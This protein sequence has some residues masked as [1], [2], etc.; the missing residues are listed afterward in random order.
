MSF[1][2]K[3]LNSNK[4]AITEFMSASSSK[5]VLVRSFCD[6][7]KFYLIRTNFR[8]ALNFAIFAICKKSRN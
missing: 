1:P 5:L 7:N 6:G 2:D 8:E 4:Y 3:R